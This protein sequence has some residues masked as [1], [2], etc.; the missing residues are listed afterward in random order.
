MYYIENIDYFR[1]NY[2]F[3]KSNIFLK[4][5]SILMEL[6][7]RNYY[8]AQSSISSYIG[9]AISISEITLNNQEIYKKS[10]QLLAR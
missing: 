10:L 3:K 7:A 2:R 9:T 5:C 1:W 8:D 6:S 4:G